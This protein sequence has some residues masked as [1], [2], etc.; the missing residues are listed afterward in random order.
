MIN[1]KKI[2]T[3]VLSCL[4][5]IC[6]AQV[7]WAANSAST[8]SDPIYKVEGDVVK[9]DLSKLPKMKNSELKTIKAKPIENGNGYRVHFIRDRLTI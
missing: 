8:P 1:Y 6:L 2:S 5:I 7:V 9:A 3:L 4:L